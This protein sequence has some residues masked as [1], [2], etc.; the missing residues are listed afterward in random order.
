MAASSATGVKRRVLENDSNFGSSE[1]DF[2]SDDS[3][4]DKDYVESSDTSKISEDSE[5]SS[6]FKQNSAGKDPSV[7]EILKNVVPKIE[8]I[9]K[10]ASIPIVSRNRV[11]DKLKKFHERY[12]QIQKNIESRIHSETMQ[13]VIEKLFP[14]KTEQTEE[15]VPIVT[16][17]NRQSSSNGVQNSHE[18]DILKT[19]I[20]MV[21]NLEERI[22]DQ[23]QIIKHL[24]EKN[25]NIEVKNAPKKQPASMQPK[26][27]TTSI[28][29][30]AHPGQET[31]KIDT[32]NRH[33]KYISLGHAQK[34][35]NQTQPPKMVSENITKPVDTEWKTPKY[36]K[37][38]R[39]TYGTGEENT[40]LRAYIPKSYI[41]VSK[42]HVD[43]TKDDL[44]RFIKNK[45]LVDA[46]CEE[47]D[48]RSRSYR[49]FKVAVLANEAKNLLDSKA[50]PKNIAVKKFIERNRNFQTN[51]EQ[52]NLT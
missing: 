50:W 4:K 45:I 7:S 29:V 33:Q 49:S 30:A 22:E 14:N 16:D 34:E 28:S 3:V 32:E 18:S 46:E 25:Y 27:R 31:P 2:D 10:N 24:K 26:I 43:F 39:A 44:N 12:K 5:I 13:D 1:S 17:K 23:K 8:E 11:W 38:N 19:Y 40:G 42:I 41:H 35:P 15:R 48:I 6:G 36:H 47:L 20:K 51:T 37:K 52:K 9:W 21:S